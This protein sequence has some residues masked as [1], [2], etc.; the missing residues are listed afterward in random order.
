VIDALAGK[1]LTA[2]SHLAHQETGIGQ[3]HIA[4]SG[5]VVG[6]GLRA[7]RG[8]VF[9]NGHAAYCNRSPEFL[10]DDGSANFPIRH[11]PPIRSLLLYLHYPIVESYNYL[12]QI[13]YFIVEL[14]NMLLYLL[15]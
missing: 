4:Q 10:K 7:V 6:D 13:H 15:Y 3:R 8:G 11:L 14:C 9:R 1:V 12:L 5:M 2:K